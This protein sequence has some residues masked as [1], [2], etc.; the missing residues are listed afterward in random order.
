MEAGEIR[1]DTADLYTIETLVEELAH[2]EPTRVLYAIDLLESLD[3]R[4]LV[5]P[6][7]L[8]HEIADVRARALRRGRG[9]RA[10]PAPSAGCAASSGR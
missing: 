10:R 7:L 6:L 4:H 3:K 1:L 5:T 2:P 8:H 9:H